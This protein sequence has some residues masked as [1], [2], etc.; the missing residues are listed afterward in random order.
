[1]KIAVV[2]FN[3]GGPDSLESVSPFLFNLFNDPAIIRL[4][5]IPRFILAKLVSSLRNKKAKGIYA[6]LGGSSPLLKNTTEQAVALEEYLNNLFKTEAQF[7]VH[8]AMRY[9]HPR[10]QSVIKD[11]EQSQ[12][13]EVVLLPLYPQYST[14]TTE[15]SFIEFMDLLNKS[16]IQ[17]KIHQI[18]CYPIQPTYIKAHVSLIEAVP[19]TTNSHI[20]FSAHGIPK[21]LVDDPYEH[22]VQKTVKAVMGSF[23]G[24][25]HTLC[26]QSKVGPKEWLGPNAEDSIKSL[27]KAGKDLIVVPISFVSDHS[28]TLVEL[29]MDYADLAKSQGVSSYRRVPSL[30]SNPLFIQSLAELIQETLKGA[31]YA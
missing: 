2:L 27:S 18:Q 24:I 19:K 15:S 13:D 12:P 30:N 6:R 3:L 7:K 22:Q 1:M 21:D 4:P 29:D 23:K 9:W 5:K 17:A 16:T 31:S 28:E 10:A 20:L 25:P 14:T 8:I 11:L 26:Y